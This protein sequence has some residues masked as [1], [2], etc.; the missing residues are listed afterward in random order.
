MVFEPANKRNPKLPTNHVPEA[1]DFFVTNIEPKTSKKTPKIPKTQKQAENIPTVNINNEFLTLLKTIANDVK[2]I[3]RE[4]TII[5]NKIE[6]TSQTLNEMT[7]KVQRV[8]C[9]T[10]NIESHLKKR[11]EKRAQSIDVVNSNMLIAPNTTQ[12]INKTFPTMEPTNTTAMTTAG[13]LSSTMEEEPT[14]YMDM[15]LYN[16]IDSDTQQPIPPD[17]HTYTPMMSKKR[18][19][20]A[21]ACFIKQQLKHCYSDEELA[22]GRLQGGVRNYKTGIQNTTSLSPNRIGAIVQQAKKRY[23]EDYKTMGNINEIV[24]SK[25]RQVKRDMQ[26]K[27]KKFNPTDD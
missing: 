17:A 15:I 21:S 19:K 4:I 24:N 11:Q 12:T 22:E 9:I 7:S 8:D 25:C 2:D 14:P 10:K 18:K 23:R 3:R 6:D 5:N 26:E 27:M 13:L 1:H 16:S 20:N